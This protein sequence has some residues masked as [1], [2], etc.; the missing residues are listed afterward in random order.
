MKNSIKK[1]ICILLT[2][3]FA[4]SVPFSCF[5]AQN[6]PYVSNG[7]YYRFSDN[8]YISFNT[9]YDEMIKYFQSRLISHSNKIEQYRFAT[10]DTEYKYNTQIDGQREAAADKLVDDIQHDIFTYESQNGSVGGDY[11][12]KI[13]DL[14]ADI[15]VGTYLSEGDEPSGSNERYYTF[16]VTFGKI[17]YSSTAEEEQYLL[18]FAKKFSSSYLTSSMSDYDKVKV[19]Y[20]FIVRNATYDHD[21]FGGKYSSSSD[22]Y[23]IAHSAYGA[24]C[25]NLLSYDSSGNLKSNSAKLDLTA[26]SSLNGEKIVSA[27]NQGLAVCEGYSKLFCY[28]CTFNGIQCRIV[29]GD[30]D[31]SSGR[32]SDAHEWDYVCLDDGSGKKWYQVDTTFASQKSYK[33]ID[34]NNYDYFLCGTVNTNFGIKNHQQAYTAQNAAVKQL[35]D[36]YSAENVSSLNDY[37]ISSADLANANIDENAK[38]IVRRRAEYSDGVKY[39]FILQNASA[40]SD[41]QRVMLDENG[42]IQYQDVAGFDYNGKA[43]EYTVFIPYLVNRSGSD[44]P[45]R[46]YSAQNVKATSVGTYPI[47]INGDSEN[48]DYSV[49]LKITPLD[50]SDVGSYDCQIQTES[51]YIGREIMPQIK[52]TDGYDNPLD[53]GSDFDLIVTKDSK[54]SAI[55]DMGTYDV[56]V[57]YK[58]NYS[59]SFSFKFTV[60]KAD[61]S[62][63]KIADTKNCKYYPQPILKQNGVANMD[64]YIKSCMPYVDVGSVRL[65]YGKD[66]DIV[67][68]KSAY[69]TDLTAKLVA[70]NNSQNLIGGKSTT[71]NY[72]ISKYDI[73]SLNG[74]YADSNKKNKYYYNGS[75]VKPTKF[76]NL[77]KTLVQGTDYKIVSYANNTKVG[78]GEVV[79]EGING[80]KGRAKLK[81]V[82]NSPTINYIK[83]T[84]NSR[85][86]L[87]STKYVYNGKVKK[88][89]VTVKNNKN[90]TVNPYYYTVSYPKG[91]K[92][93]GS[94]TIKIRFR[95]GY[96]GTFSVKYTIVPKG[97]SISSIKAKSKAFYVKWKKQSSQTTGYQIQ[98]STSSKFK[99][100]KTVSVSKKSTTS[101]TV[102][103]LSKKKKYYVRVRTY[104]KVGKAYYYSS[105][106]KVVSVKTK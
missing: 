57:K 97:T 61:L 85:V 9:D 68:P 98:Y 58:N 35:Y 33:E 103:K 52:I 43:S 73:S 49:N 21:V 99:R 79:I 105:W 6:A 59:G 47:Y 88:P 23:R 100:A 29:D 63:L 44:C 86:V 50:M 48:H 31:A 41:S 27:Y 75:A 20:D 4:M 56:T 76:D 93:V 70:L 15:N 77:D 91:M 2:L 67:L 13:T 14:S 24:L 25:G 32:Q 96:K 36:W 74:Q 19:I 62:V 39:V 5:A 92:N 106:S 30:F 65:Y 38:F 80:C 40:N 66:Y 102:K 46:E 37:T 83:P 72:R 16:S 11:L 34:F 22:R 101:A 55:C 1:I 51:G 10:T 53:N 78:T 81:F 104:K 45:S 69:E 8:E 94:Y 12:Y 60:G 3:A 84:S 28:L 82:I 26:K 54:P 42:K 17:E 64:E 95:N 7:L 87:S 71:F 90:Q 18:G 89:S